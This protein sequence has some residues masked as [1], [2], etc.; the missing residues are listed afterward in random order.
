MDLFSGS[1][2]LGSCFLFLNQEKNDRRGSDKK[3]KIILKFWKFLRTFFNVPDL[4]DC[5][6]RE[7]FE[8]E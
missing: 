7:T 1:T 5:N 4:T 2:R 3:K 6:I 8:I